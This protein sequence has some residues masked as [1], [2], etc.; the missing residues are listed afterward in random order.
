MTAADL[1][2]I[3]IVIAKQ[4]ITDVLARYCRGIDRC[5]LETLKSVFW[6]DAI[7]D[8]YGGSPS[9]AHAWCYMA[10]KLID[11][12]GDTAIGETY[13]TAYHQVTAPEG[14]REMIV[15]G[16]YLDKFERRNEEWRISERIYVMDWNQNGPSTA[17]FT[18]G[19]YA[20]LK[21]VGKRFPDDPIYRI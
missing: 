10:N 18:D 5:H 11:I 19:L 6:P 7:A 15:G 8:Y 3:H 4:D 16:R 1:K 2:A 12:E 21:L 13:G 9:N 14:R 17:N 20:T